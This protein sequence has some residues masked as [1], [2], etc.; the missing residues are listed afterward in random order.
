MARIGRFYAFLSNIIATIRAL[1]KPRAAMAAEIIALRHQVCVLS[2]TTKRPQLRPLD[3]ILWVWLS[4]MWKGWRNAL[5]IVKPDTVTSWHRRGWRLYWRWK[6]QRKLG[7][8]QTAPEIRELIKRLST[9]NP[10]WGAPRIHGE[11]LMLGIEVSQA[12]VAKYMIRHRK[13]ASSTWRTF[14][15]NQS[16]VAC[17]FF[18]VPTLTFKTLYVFV[19]LRHCDRRMIYIGVT[20]NPTDQ[21]TSGHILGAFPWEE[22]PNTC[23]AT[24]TTSTLRNRRK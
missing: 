15:Q 24:T 16:L 23:S 18:T 9:E 7:H 2:R 12:T 17:D 13:P 1:L 22:A 4:R 10:L 8:P 11:L 3:R 5:V 6:S 20:E 21:W 19:I 14:L